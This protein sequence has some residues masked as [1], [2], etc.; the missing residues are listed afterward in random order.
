[1]DVP[2]WERVLA[3]LASGADDR[4]DRL[5]DRLGRGRRDALVTPYRGWGTRQE[6]VVRGRLLRDPGLE[7]PR[8]EAGVLQNLL[9]MYRRLESDEVRGARVEATFGRE[10]ARAETDTEGFFEL[11]VPVTETLDDRAWHAV[12]VRAPDLD[13]APA[14]A[15][16]VV[17]AR[18][19]EMVVVSDLDD[20]VVQTGATD[21]L[22]MA[23]TVFL[24]N[25]YTRVPFPG[26]AAFYAALHQGR[27][28]RPVNPIVYVSSSPWNLYDLLTDFLQIQAIP[29]GPLVLRD[30]GVSEGELLPVRHRAHKERAIRELLATWRDLPFVLVG[31][32]GQE[33]PEIYSA[34]VGEHPGRV[35]TVYIRDVTRHPERTAAMTKLAEA[36][37]GSR[38]RLVVVDDTLGAA[39]DAA[40]QGFIENEAVLAVEGRRAAD[41]A[42]D[43]TGAPEA[44]EDVPLAA[45]GPREVVIAPVH[46][47]AARAAVESGVV[48]DALADRPAQHAEGEPAPTVVVE[49]P[50]RQDG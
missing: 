30:W 20:T 22:H 11:R 21:L 28:D 40:T 25:A 34:L 46:P 49:S 50:P 18:D 8:P 1:M 32:S 23:R 26:V 36:V 7:A 2:G 33:D 43:A 41:A 37:L 9:D 35:K 47:A 13:A 42:I 17:P 19:A 38:S 29:Q 44:A 27:R 3:R 10:V 39:R 12:E 24:A 15:Q 45:P 4:L 5:K 48:A 16:V 31:D 14:L 6:L